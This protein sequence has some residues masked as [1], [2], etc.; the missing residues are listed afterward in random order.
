MPA[1]VRIHGHNDSPEAIREPTY[2][3]SH[4][5]LGY[6]HPWG[7]TMGFRA[8]LNYRKLPARG[9]MPADAGLD[10]SNEYGLVSAPIRVLDG[11]LFRVET[12]ANLEVGIYTTEL[13][14]GQFAPDLSNPKFNPNTPLDPDTLTQTIN[15]RFPPRSF[16]QP[17]LIARKYYSDSS[18]DFIYY[19]P[20]HPDGDYYAPFTKPEFWWTFHADG[21]GISPYNWERTASSPTKESGGRLQSSPSGARSHPFNGAVLHY[22]GVTVRPEDT[23]KSI[24]P[25][26]GDYR[27]VAGSHTVPNDVFQPS[28]WYSDTRRKPIQ[29]RRLPAGESYSI[30]FNPTL[31]KAVSPSGPAGCSTGTTTGRSWFPTCNTRP[32]LFRIFPTEPGHGKTSGIS[33]PE[34]G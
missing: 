20:R 12:P 6:Y 27:L 21:V 17:Q 19:S 26:H 4:L 31:P 13:G 5:F 16:P 29:P 34:S 3:L 23:F 7:G 30:R 33:T 8:F 22:S 18:G 9:V 24:V 28:E 14:A 1:V 32:I 15:L 2:R 10:A 11:S 25:Y